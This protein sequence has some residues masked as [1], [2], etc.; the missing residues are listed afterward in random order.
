MTDILK[1][2]ISSIQNIHSFIFM[3]SQLKHKR[4][5][6]FLLCPYLNKNTSE[7]IRN[8]HVHLNKTK[9]QFYDKDSQIICVPILSEDETYPHL[10][11]PLSLNNL[12]TFA[13]LGLILKRILFYFSWAQIIVF[14]PRFYYFLRRHLPCFNALCF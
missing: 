7:L 3:R 9:V 8:L 11:F 6:V 10:R 5:S 1:R 4:A 2:V 13:K 12:N 14:S